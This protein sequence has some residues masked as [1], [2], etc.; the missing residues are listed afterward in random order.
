MLTSLNGLGTLFLEV[1]FLCKDAVLISMQT[2]SNGKASLDQ[3][4]K[5]RLAIKL[6]QLR[7][8]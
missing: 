5:E 7:P 8:K 6:I 2:L 1:L 3:M 4:V